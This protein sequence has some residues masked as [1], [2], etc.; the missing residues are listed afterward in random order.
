MF[1]VSDTT[2]IYSGG[3]TGIATVGSGV[4]ITLFDPATKAVLGRKHFDAPELPDE[5]N[6]AGLEYYEARQAAQVAAYLKNLPR[7]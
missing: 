2:A 3:A 4:T 1:V 5:T 7:R 6:R